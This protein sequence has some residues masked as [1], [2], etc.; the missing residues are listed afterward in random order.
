MKTVVNNNSSSSSFLVVEIF[1]ANIYIV[2]VEV[3]SFPLFE[4]REYLVG[5]RG[6]GRQFEDFLVD[7]V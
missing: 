4:A 5:K 6:L 1:L 2:V 7:P 3:E